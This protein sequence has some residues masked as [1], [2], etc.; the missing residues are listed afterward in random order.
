[1]LE[2]AMLLIHIVN[3]LLEKPTK[4]LLSVTEDIY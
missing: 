3:F 4:V 2:Y 1:M